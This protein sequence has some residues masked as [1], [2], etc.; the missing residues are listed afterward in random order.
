MDNHECPHMDRLAHT[1]DEMFR[2][3]DNDNRPPDFG[4]QYS[5]VLAWREAERQLTSDFSPYSAGFNSCEY[6]K[7]NTS[8]EFSLY[9]GG[10]LSGLTIVVY[11][12]GGKLV[13][14]Y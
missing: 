12:D 4:S 7:E 5:R 11:W 10:V 9:K 8:W 2:R 3:A 14:E 6:D 1:E 13:A